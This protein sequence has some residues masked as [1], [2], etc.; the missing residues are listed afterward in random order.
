MPSEKAYEELAIIPTFTPE[1]SPT[2]TP[3]V[4]PLPEVISNQT[5]K[6]VTPPV[7]EVQ[8]IDDELKSKGE[9]KINLPE[10]IK[11][12]NLSVQEV[13]AKNGRT[14]LAV[15]ASREGTYN[16]PILSGGKI[17]KVRA[18][19]ISNFSSLGVLTS[20]NEVWFYFF[21]TPSQAFVKEGEIVKIGQEA[22]STDYNPNTQN[23]QIFTKFLETQISNNTPHNTV[24]LI[25]R[26]LA[27]GQG[28]DLTFKDIRITPQGEVILVGSS[29]YTQ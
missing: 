7:E 2:A 24:V 12:N 28:L 15:T 17:D 19:V 16:F 29:T 22:I 18:G 10:A 14:L 11:D 9:F 25:G 13:H 26:S 8:K 6:F 23:G 27:S 1:A 21:P 3:E 20:N 5:V 4:K